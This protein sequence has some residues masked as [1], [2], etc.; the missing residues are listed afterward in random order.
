MADCE[1]ADCGVEAD[2]ML[3]SKAGRYGAVGQTLLPALSCGATNYYLY[4]D[5]TRSRNPNDS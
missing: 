5:R 2:K 1:A 3:V 4:E